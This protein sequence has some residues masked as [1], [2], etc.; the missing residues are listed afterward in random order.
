MYWKTSLGPDE[1]QETGHGAS[2]ESRVPH[3]KSRRAHLLTTRLRVVVLPSAAVRS[4]RGMRRP[5][6][7]SANAALPAGTSVIGCA[8]DAH[9]PR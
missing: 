5:R 3:L 8:V 4:P 7:P 2:G 6:T 1:I 9:F